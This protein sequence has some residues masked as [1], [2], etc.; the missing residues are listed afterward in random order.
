MSRDTQSIGLRFTPTPTA[1][2]WPTTLGLWSAASGSVAAFGSQFGAGLMRPDI[3]EG[4]SGLFHIAADGLTVAVQPEHGPAPTADILFD[5]WDNG[6]TRRNDR[7]LVVLKRSVADHPAPRDVPCP[8]W[9][10]KA[11]VDL[12]CGHADPNVKRP[13]VTFC[14]V[15]GRP[16]ERLEMVRRF[17]GA[18]EVDFRCTPRPK[19]NDPDKAGYLDSIRAAH[20]VLCPRGVG[21]WS[22]RLYETL[23]AGRV[24]IVSPDQHT[25]APASLHRHVTL[26]HAV[27]PASV[28][29]IWDRFRE[30]GHWPEVHRRNR[31]GWLFAASPLASVRWIHR[32][33]SERLEARL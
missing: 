20:F 24:P 19:F 22:Y 21:R 16:R 9:P 10:R 13:V 2:D 26:L 15:A 7:A 30:G 11:T 6:H 25:I 8:A 3:L 32:V 18:S 14:G 1:E 28:R 17:V 4:V 5:P 33:V 12:E 31:Q 23:A 27:T 29:W